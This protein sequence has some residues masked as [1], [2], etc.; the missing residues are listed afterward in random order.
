[1]E[2]IVRFNC[3]MK[4]LSHKKAFSLLIQR[5]F[6]IYTALENTIR[7]LRFR[8]LQCQLY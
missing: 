2:N 4:Y 1:M 6:I 3:L 7:H 8:H 5:L